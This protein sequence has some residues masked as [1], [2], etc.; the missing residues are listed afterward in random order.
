MKSFR[1]II[2]TIIG[3]LQFAYS[4]APS[5]LAGI[6]SD[7]D[8][9][10]PVYGARVRVLGTGFSTLTD[11]SGIYS[12]VLDMPE[13]Y[14]QV[15]ITAPGYQHRV[16]KERYFN[17]GQAYSLNIALSP[18]AVGMNTVIMRSTSHR[19]ENALAAPAAVSV[20]TAGSLRGEM[21]LSPDLVLKNAPGADIAATGIDRREITLRGF[22]AAFNPSPYLLADYRQ[23]SLPSLGVNLYAS[24]PLVL[25]DIYR[26][27]VLSD[28]ASALYGPGGESGVVHFISKNPFYHPGLAVSVGG[29]ERSA[30][31]GALRGAASIAGVVGFKIT[32]QYAKG[33]DWE[34]DPQ[35]HFDE[36][37]LDADAPGVERRYDY[38]KMNANAQLQFKIGSSARITANGGLA[39]V[40]EN[41]L[42]PLGTAYADSLAYSYGQVIVQA[43]RFFAQGYVNRITAGQLFLY[44]LD[45]SVVDKGVQTRGQAQYDFHFSEGRLQVVAGSDVKVTRPQTEGS[46]YGRNEENDEVREIGVYFHSLYK[47]SPRLDFILALRGD[48]N[49]LFEEVKISPRAGL[50]Y[51]LHPAHFTRLTFNHAVSM[52]AYP[53]L[54]LDFPLRRV[55]LNQAGGYEL[56]LQGRGAGRGFTFNGFYTHREVAVMAALP[57]LQPNPFGDF[58]SLDEFP[59]A[60]GYLNTAQAAGALFSGPET[61]IPPDLRRLDAGQREALVQLLELMGREALKNGETAPGILGIP[62]NS[63]L[64]Y[65]AVSGPKDVPALKMPST[66]TLEAGY[67]GLFKNRFLVGINAFY[68]RKKNFVSPLLLETPFVYLPVDYVRDQVLDFITSGDPAVEQLIRELG[69][70]PVATVGLMTHLYS[71]TPSGIVQPDAG[72]D[73]SGVTPVSS[74]TALGGLLTYRNFGRV[75]YWGFDLDMQYLPNYNLTLFWNLSYISDDFFDNKE[76]KATRTKLSLALNAPTFK[77]KFGMLYHPPKGWSLG[78]A[79]RY[80]RGFPVQ[81]GPYLGGLPEPYG[82]GRGGVEQYIVFDVNAGRGLE[83]VIPGLRLDVAVN[84]LFN[85]KHREFVGAPKI[86][87]LALAQLS[88]SL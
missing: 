42:T 81:S 54:F 79:V 23:A 63:A 18:T 50:V 77:T 15:E 51:K 4:Q 58:V 65:E 59:A 13:G 16:L 76:L 69:I 61:N 35:D 88:F 17:A 25:S 10:K 29:G 86:G 8:D 66:Q 19:P 47:Y 62:D 24:L 67:R 36:Q 37:Q 71:Q 68:T 73:G 44:G 34:L 40:K 22:N 31:F 55:L 1:I 43:G 49:D 82:T 87:R 53:S 21:A 60:L 38:K 56:I 20:I 83:K 27:E 32:G 72:E 9:G 12:M 48:Y 28:P 74:P 2:F 46:I 30:S 3:L 80:V 41:L 57:D 45:T 52:P 39:V 7:D 6:I 75:R 5:T 11:S 26:I 70:G 84:N 33:R 64:G 85:Y 14:Y 78:V